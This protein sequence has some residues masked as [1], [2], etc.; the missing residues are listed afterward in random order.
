MAAPEPLARRELIVE[1]TRS[2]VTEVGVHGA[3]IAR[4]AETAGISQGGIYRH[5]RS[6]T[7]ILL[8]VIDEIFDQIFSLYEVPAGTDP[9]DHLREIARRHSQLM[10]DDSR[11]FARPW[12]EF[13]AAAPRLG[14]REAVRAKQMTAVDALESIV[15]AGQRSGTIRAEVSARQI[16]WEFLNWAWGENVGSAL[17]LSD[18]IG[19]GNSA[20]LIDLILTSASAPSPPIPT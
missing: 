2:L 1:T 20:R 8:A 19:G 13:V 12:L 10:T 7:D 5:F 17:G 18:F 3:T 4:I 15:V 14:L 6:R 9:L 11:S 16:A